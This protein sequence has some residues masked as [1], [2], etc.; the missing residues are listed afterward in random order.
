MKTWSGILGASLAALLAL[1]APPEASAD[2]ATDGLYLGIGPAVA[3]E[4]FDGGGSVDP[5]EAW[6]FNAW[7]GY[8]FNQWL[9]AELQLEYLNG[10]D[11][12]FFGADIDAEVV[13]FHATAKLFP[14]ASL[15]PARVQ[16]FLRAGP[17][18]TWIEFEADFGA[19]SDDADFSARLGGGLDVYLTERIALQVASSYLLTTGDVDD[20]SHVDLVFGVQ[21]LFP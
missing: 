11:F 2:P 17:G 3:F 7:G 8:R 14:L 12:S 4:D 16:P 10:F 5:D 21:I 9:G 18:M 19:D 1:A 13:N 15:L 20:V 6:G